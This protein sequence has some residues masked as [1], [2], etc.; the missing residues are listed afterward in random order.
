MQKE[1]QLIHGNMAR[2]AT[3]N[4]S[5]AKARIVGNEPLASSI[6]KSITLALRRPCVR[7]S[8]RSP[9]KIFDDSL[10]SAIYDIESD[11]RG[12]LFQR[13]IKYGPHNPAEPPVFES[14]GKKTLSDL[15]LGKCVEF[16]F[17]HM[18]NR[19]KGE[20]AELL[21]LEACSSL[22]M[23]L[24]KEKKL[25]Q[26]TR[27]YWGEDIQEH[28]SFRARNSDNSRVKDFAKG[29]DGLMVEPL[30]SNRKN[31]KFSLRV[32][33]LI[34]VKSMHLS[35]R[36]VLAQIDHHAA[37]LGKDIW[38]AGSEQPVWHFIYVSEYA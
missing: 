37:R 16:I 28:R 11:P 10:N 8:A 13:L 35:Q 1:H 7:L 3:K 22:V 27:L 18:V 24:I 33:G 21:A 4:P 25:S 23:E 26:R 5:D 19:F 31:G 38:L 29:A 30:A 6:H 9:Q 2:I 34:E 15:E 14:D 20:L 12:L 17:S 32:I 36:K